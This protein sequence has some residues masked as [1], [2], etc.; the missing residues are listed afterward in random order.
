MCEQIHRENRIDVAGRR[1]PVFSLCGES[2]SLVLR[3]LRRVILERMCNLRGFKV[4]HPGVD[5]SID[6]QRRSACAIVW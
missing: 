2:S 3:R 1:L 5:T 6:A 4:P